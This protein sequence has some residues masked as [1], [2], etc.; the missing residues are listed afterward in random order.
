VQTK[1]GVT[2]F[3]RVWESLRKKTGQKREE[4][5]QVRSQMVSSEEP[6]IHTAAS[7]NDTKPFKDPEAWADR[8]GKRVQSKK[9][10]KKRK[11][12]AFS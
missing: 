11:V 6:N 9:D 3:S 8:R 2:D 12:N 7:A 1:V 5:R 4:R 10:S